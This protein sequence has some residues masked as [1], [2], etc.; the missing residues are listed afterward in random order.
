MFGIFNGPGDNPHKPEVIKVVP[1]EREQI[2]EIA[3]EIVMEAFRRLDIIN[4]N[5]FKE[6]RR[7]LEFSRRW[8][9]RVEYFSA[10]FIVVIVTF[11]LLGIL[12]FCSRSVVNE[13]KLELRGTNAVSESPTH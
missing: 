6:A 5:D 8:R 9:G 2:K 10:K 12:G 13:L 3:C 4:E 11:C 7:D 1:A